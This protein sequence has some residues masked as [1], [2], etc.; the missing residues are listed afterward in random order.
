MK[1]HMLLVGIL[2]LGCVSLL[3][4]VSLPASAE[5]APAPS[6]DP[7]IGEYEGVYHWVGRPDMPSTGMV[8]GEGPALYRL[9]ARCKGDGEVFN[10]VEIHGQLEGARVVFRGTSNSAFWNAQAT[11]TEIKVDGDYGNSFELKKIE[12]KSPTEGQAP[13]KDAVVL[14]AFEPGKAPDLSAWT[15]DKWKVFDDGS[16][17]VQPGSGSNT[18]KA[19]IGDCQMHLE[20]YLPHMPGEFGQG[21]ANSGVYVQ[22]RYEIQVLDSFGVLFNAS[23]DC[24]SFYRVSTARVNATLPPEHWQTYDIDFR[25]ARLNADG[26]QKEPARI[27]VKH[28]GILI[29]E[30][31]S[32]PE[33]T[34]GGVAGPGASEDILQ[35]QDHGNRVRYRN[36]WYVPGKDAPVSK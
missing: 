26:T 25:A 11:G 36:I 34:A 10:Q 22:N 32:L 12:R 15:N 14:L 2:A 5:P 7:F 19:K 3:A 33:P 31:I 28:N 8:V 9:V 30:N 21:R 17:C 18:T 13:P 1:P 27:S 20:F 6:G 16:M 4:S 29:Q 35:L 24:G 23:G